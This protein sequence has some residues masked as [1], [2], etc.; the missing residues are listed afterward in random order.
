MQKTHRRTHAGT[1]GFTLIEL[2]VVI[3]IIAILA[4][5]LFPVF[6]QAREKA[7]TASCLSNQKQIALAIMQYVQD[8]DESLPLSEFAGGGGATWEN[9]IN[10]YVKAGDAVGTYTRSGAIWAC[11]SFAHPEEW[12]QYKGLDNVF[13]WGTPITL[14]DVDEPAGKIMVFEAG[15]N[16]PP[17]DPQTW[18]YRDSTSAE[19][20]WTSTYTVPAAFAKD[21]DGKFPGDWGGCNRYPRYRHNGTSNFVFI[22]GHSKALPKG[23][24]SWY[25]HIW[26][27]NFN[28]TPW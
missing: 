3:A 4:A 17:S 8:Y 21:C 2:L 19:W 7:R 9:V 20:F 25:K 12:S 22:D 14:A 16:F 15:S 11:P 24:L 28:G 5:I 26:R 23:Q 1:F 6:A 13:A 27:Q 10:P 18:G